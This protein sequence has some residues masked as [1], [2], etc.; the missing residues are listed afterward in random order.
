MKEI[1][2]APKLELLVFAAADIIATSNLITRLLLDTPT[3]QLS[4]TPTDPNL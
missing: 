2:T 3:D 1:Y 4:E